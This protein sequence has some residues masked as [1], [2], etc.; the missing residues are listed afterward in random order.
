MENSTQTAG[1]Y[2]A[3]DTLGS[4]RAT[5]LTVAGSFLAVYLF[6]A[7]LSF[8]LL[9][10]AP[11]VGK[12]GNIFKWEWPA[13]LLYSFRAKEVLDEGYKKVCGQNTQ[14]TDGGGRHDK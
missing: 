7:A 13:R 10:K 14:Y 5:F 12:S 8:P 2:A 6:H 11:V 3:L 4:G 9:V 1:S